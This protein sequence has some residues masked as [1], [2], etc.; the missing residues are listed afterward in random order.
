M[1]ALLGA[2]L[3]CGL[4]ALAVPAGAVSKP[5]AEQQYIIPS[6]SGT[7]PG[8]NPGS[9][10]GGQ[11]PAASSG[12]GGS[13]AAPILLGGVAAIAVAGGLIAYRKRRN[14]GEQG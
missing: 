7:G 4:L 8:G 10:A 1:R 3:A 14:L 12:G 2:L 5:P 6:P 11:N 9:G 13:S